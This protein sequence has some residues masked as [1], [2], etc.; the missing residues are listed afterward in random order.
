MTYYTQ[1]MIKTTIQGKVV[2]VQICAKGAK[3]EFLARLFGPQPGM[4]I[5]E[6]N[7]YIVQTLLGPVFPYDCIKNVSFRISLRWPIHIICIIPVDRTKFYLSCRT[8]RY[9]SST[10]LQSNLDLTA[11]YTRSSNG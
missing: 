6:R 1:E 4:Q 10:F 7:L 8:M 3:L 11:S 2:H 5:L 9:I